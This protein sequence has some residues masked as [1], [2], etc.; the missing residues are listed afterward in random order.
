MKIV[1]TLNELMKNE[2]FYNNHFSQIVGP[3]SGIIRN[4]A[5]NFSFSELYEIV[6]LSSTLKCNVRSIY[7]RIDFRSDLSVMNS[8]FESIESSS[9]S[10]TIHIFWTHTQNETFARSS[11]AGNWTPNHFV[12]LLFPTDYYRIQNDWTLSKIATPSL[13]SY[14]FQLKT[15]KE[16]HVHLQTPTESTIKNSMHTQVRIP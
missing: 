6:A 15:E 7:P 16:K 14:S 4:V 9:S 2:N 13:V 11:N 8:T 1:R 12:S 10:K 5:R 3:V